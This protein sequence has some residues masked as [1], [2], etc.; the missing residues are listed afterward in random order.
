MEQPKPLLNLNSGQLWNS[1]ELKKCHQAIAVDFNLRDFASAY[2]DFVGSNTLIGLPIR[3]ILEK[4]LTN[5]NWEAV[6][7]SLAR[8]VAA[9]PHSCDVERMISS[10][11]RVKSCGP[12]KHL[13]RS[14]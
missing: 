14:P 1:D 7:V 6:S 10:Y 2:K 11:N 3:A 8:V 13:S 5:P 12:V 9:T 4:S